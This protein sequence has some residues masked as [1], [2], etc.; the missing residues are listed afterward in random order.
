MNS[1]NF[2]YKLDLFKLHE[3]GK[4][5]GQLLGFT[6]TQRVGDN[7]PNSLFSNP[8]QFKPKA[9]TP[10]NSMPSPTLYNSKVKRPLL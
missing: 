1:N 5:R 9:K 10:F 8:L 4:Y 7:I 2:V 6:A 3:P